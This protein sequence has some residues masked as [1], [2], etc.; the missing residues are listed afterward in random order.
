VLTL[1]R[2]LVAGRSGVAAVVQTIATKAL[3]V[4]ITLIT[5]VMTA[6]FLAPAGRGEQAAMV[7]WPQLLAYSM[8]LG[9][10][11][12]LRYYLRRNPSEQP[13]LTA[14]A[15]ALAGALGL[16]AGLVGVLLIPRWLSQYD[17]SVIAFAL[18]LLVLVPVEM[19][20]LVFIALLHARGEFA[21][22]N[23]IALIPP[24]TTLVILLVLVGLRDV[25]PY[26]STLAYVVPSALTLVWMLWRLHPILALQRRGLALSAR[27]LLHYGSRSYGIDLLSVLS[28]QIDQVLV[29]GLLTAG[30]MGIY[31]V[32][33][34]VSRVLAIIH[35]SVNTVLFPKAASL[36]IDEIIAMTNRAARL[37]ATTTLLAALALI[38]VAPLV[39]PLLYGGAF[40]AAV[41]IAQLLAIEVVL[42][43]TAGVLGQAFLAAGRPIIVTLVQAVGLGTCVPLMLWL[44]P[45]YGL[46]G[47]AIALL[48][49]TIL[50]LVI[51]SLGY[52]ALLRA[53]LPD[54]VIST[55]DVSHLRAALSTALR[56]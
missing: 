47:A 53:P 54:L 1:G 16:I 11:M 5:G 26:S 32:A 31:T 3:I 48:S 24:T 2:W 30:S 25:N 33:L 19:V 55:S 42:G 6:R 50:R 35:T 44:I 4:L 7:M 43:G 46:F 56:R 38:I 20:N 45:R 13:Q 14:A 10:P 39:I 27:R 23:H 21:T 40:L 18:G 9:I 28:M 41:P 51:V 8:T 37:S 22:A 52:P 17:P 36:D 15:L 34:S 49:S 29:V 12:S